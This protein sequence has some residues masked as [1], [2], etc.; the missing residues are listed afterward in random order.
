MGM[1][2]PEEEEA[3]DDRDDGAHSKLVLLHSL[4]VLAAVRALCCHRPV[5]NPSHH[6][7]LHTNKIDNM[8]QTI[9]CAG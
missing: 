1:G 2:A 9:A 3:N 6:I 5:Q 4:D 8:K 7:Y